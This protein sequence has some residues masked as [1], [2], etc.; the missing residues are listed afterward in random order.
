MTIYVAHFRELKEIA[1]I[2]IAIG[3]YAVMLISGIIILLTK[4]NIGAYICNISTSDR[5]IT[6]HTTR[7]NPPTTTTTHFT[8][9]REHLTPSPMHSVYIS[10]LLFVIWK[11]INKPKQFNLRTFHVQSITLESNFTKG[12]LG[13]DLFKYNCIHLLNQQITCQTS[14]IICTRF[15][16]YFRVIKNTVY[17][18]AIG[19]FNDIT[20][21]STPYLALN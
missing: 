4:S 6:L 17:N 10:G 3:E 7:N 9:I 8:S 20:F 5:Y 15:T 19:D 21:S 2:S 18:M 14:L 1:R 11:M 13:R 16:H 12:F